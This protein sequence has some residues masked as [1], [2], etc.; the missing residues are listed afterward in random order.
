MLSISC[1]CVHTVAGKIAERL[2]FDLVS[3]ITHLF[4]LIAHTVIQHIC[5]FVRAF[6]CI[7]E[8]RKELRLNI[9]I[10]SALYLSWKKANICLL[11]LYAESFDSKKYR[12][13]WR[14]IFFLNAGSYRCTCVNGWTGA[15]CSINVDDCTPNPCY[16]GSTC[17]DEVARFFCNCS[18]GRTG[19]LMCL[20]LRV[21]LF[22]K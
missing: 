11:C 7:L 21:C 16:A 8:T 3:L 6:L 4:E 18:Y 1:V 17:L 22:L 15:D 12:P 13:Y 14:L 5:I 10:A 9:N 20:L 19:L 2:R